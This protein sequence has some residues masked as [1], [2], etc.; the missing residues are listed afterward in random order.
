M[1]RLS[2][3]LAVAVALGAAGPLAFAAGGPRGDFRDDASGFEVKVPPNFLQTPAQ[4]ADGRGVTLKRAG[5]EGVFCTATFAPDE[6]ARGAEGAGV[7]QVAAKWRAGPA[8]KGRAF[9]SAAPFNPSRSEGLS[10]I[11]IVSDRRGDLVGYPGQKRRSLTILWETPKGGASLVCE[12]PKVRFGILR[13]EFEE[14]AKDVTP[15]R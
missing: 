1:R 2:F 14:L 4:P 8:A 11:A 9:V 12:G 15:P 3:G 10:A 7:K 5:D 6:T 13:R